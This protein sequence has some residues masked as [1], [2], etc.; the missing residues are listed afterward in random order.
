MSF[1]RVKTYMEVLEFDYAVCEVDKCIEKSEKLAMTE[2]RYVDFCM[3]H[4]QQHIL[5]ER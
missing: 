3:K 5:G 4:Y 2:T 1:F